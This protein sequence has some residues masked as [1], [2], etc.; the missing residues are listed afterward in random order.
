M[1]TTYVYIE[2]G[3]YRGMH[4]MYIESGD[5]RWMHNMC[6]CVLHP[7]AQELPSTWAPLTR[8]VLPMASLLLNMV[9]TERTPH[10]LHMLRKRCWCTCVLH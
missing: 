3:D 8:S 1:R 4:N 7:V 10:W 9:D 2:S 5:Y 6:V